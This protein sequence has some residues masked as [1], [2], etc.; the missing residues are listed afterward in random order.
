MSRKK[1]KI[2]REQFDELYSTA[3]LYNHW[4]IESMRYALYEIKR[5]LDG[6]K[7]TE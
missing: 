5:K 1:I 6:I 2:S 4:S 3:T 7:H